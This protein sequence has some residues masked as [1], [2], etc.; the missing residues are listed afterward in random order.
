MKG[1]EAEVDAGDVLVTETRKVQERGEDGKK[2]KFLN[3][4]RY[5]A[6]T[7]GLEKGDE[8]DIDVYEDRYVVR[9]PQE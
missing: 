8:V 9:Q 1:R 4:P 2:G 7:L 6:R 3:I 5:A